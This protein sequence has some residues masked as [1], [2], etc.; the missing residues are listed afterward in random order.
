MQ[1]WTQSLVEA[2]DSLRELEESIRHVRTGW[3]LTGANMNG[4][5]G[6]VSPT[7]DSLR[8]LGSELSGILRRCEKLPTEAVSVVESA[9]VNL[10]A[11]TL[12]D[13]DAAGRQVLELLAKQAEAMTQAATLVQQGEKSGLP[14][15]SSRKLD[16]ERV[17]LLDRT[18]D[19]LDS[20]PWSTGNKPGD[21]EDA[22]AA[23]E[24]RQGMPSFEALVRLAKQFPPPPEWFRGE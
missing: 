16:G 7:P 12:P 13:W 5:G 4:A 20:W 14:L 22:A 19:F 10:D 11:N 8:Q 23:R 3:P 24:A 9:W 21:E 1:S 2:E 6:G 17:H 15:P 18:R